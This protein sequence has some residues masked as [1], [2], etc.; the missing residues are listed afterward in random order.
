MPGPGIRFYPPLYFLAG[1]AVAW[2]LHRRIAFEIDGA[3]V[4]ALQWRLGLALVVLGSALMAWAIATFTRAGTTVRPDRAASRI[5]IAGPYRFSR[6]PIYLADSL[7]YVGLALIANSA[8][9]LLLLPFVLVLLTT[10]VI[11]REEGYLRGAF[12]AEYDDYR[13]RTR[14]WM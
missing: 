3:G 6:N 10:R 7:V 11:R 12:G 5:V 14:R 13:R 2:G 4:G 1:G 9:A 8:W